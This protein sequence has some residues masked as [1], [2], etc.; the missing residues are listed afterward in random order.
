MT[1]TE[2]FDVFLA[3]SDGPGIIRLPGMAVFSQEL[4]AVRQSIRRFNNNYDDVVI[5]NL[6]FN[7]ILC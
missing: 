7:R 2:I 5:Y 6:S 1:M 4:Q 3:Q